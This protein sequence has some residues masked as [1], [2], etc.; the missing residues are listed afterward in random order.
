MHQVSIILPARNEEQHIQACLRSILAQDYPGIREVLVIDGSSED[1]TR[2]L[3]AAA[4]KIDSRIRLLD[5]PKRTVTA[6]VNAGFAAARCPLIVRMDAHADYAADY[7]SQCVKALN[8]TGAAV[9]GGR[10]T[11]VYGCTRLAQAIGALH[12]SPFGIRAARFRRAGQGGFVDTVWCGAYRAAALD[13][14]G[15][16]VREQLTRAE[17]IELHA[18]LRAAGHRIYLSPDIQARYCPRDS[19][20]GLLGQS[21]ANGRGVV[22]ALAV[23]R[24]AVSLRHFV[25]AAFVCSLLAAGCLAACGPPWAWAFPAVAGSYALA[26]LCFSLRVG[27]RRGAGV[28]ILVPPLYLAVHLAY[29]LG[30]L[31]GMLLYLPRAAVLSV[32]QLLQR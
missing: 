9:V 22:Q 7:I 12:E 10:T 5:N 13:E 23:N 21:F 19:V 4:A 14:V 2:E 25:P 28:G 18:R 30:S 27:V 17:D 8:E 32:R 31:L 24:R 20:P 11:P 1:R 3:V 29:G 6:A 26:N 16:C 15:R